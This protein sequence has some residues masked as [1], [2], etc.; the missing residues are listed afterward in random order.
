[1]GNTEKSSPSEAALWLGAIV[2]VRDEK[3]REQL[4][5]LLKST[6]QP[7]GVVEKAIQQARA[8]GFVEGAD[9]RMKGYPEVGKIVRHNTVSWGFYSGDLYS[10]VVEFERGT[11]EYGEESLELV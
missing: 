10:I 6:K 5:D 11:F 4:H 3:E 1:M 9:V 7:E 2:G 8:N